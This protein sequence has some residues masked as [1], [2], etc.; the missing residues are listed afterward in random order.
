FFHTFLS[1]VY[2][3][4]SLSCFILLLRERTTPARCALMSPLRSTPSA[5][6]LLTPSADQLQAGTGM[7]WAGILG[8][9]GLT[10]PAKVGATLLR[11]VSG[12]P[13]RLNCACSVDN[14]EVWSKG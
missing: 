6:P 11:L 14:I 8:L 3:S 4:I 7:A 10:N 13:A 2:Y 1:P 12:G 5:C 9:V